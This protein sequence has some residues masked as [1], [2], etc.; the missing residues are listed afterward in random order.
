MQLGLS[1]KVLFVM[2]FVSTTAVIFLTDQK[3]ITNLVF[4]TVPLFVWLLV[5][6]QSN[7]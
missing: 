5:P 1:R 7:G 4:L 2:Y 3:W 6:R